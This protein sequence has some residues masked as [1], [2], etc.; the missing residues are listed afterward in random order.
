MA[1]TVKEAR[2]PCLA[3]L[4]CLLAAALAIT[5][6]VQP[7]YLTQHGPI[8]GTYRAWYTSVTTVVASAFASFVASQIRLLWVGGSDQLDSYMPL[9]FGPPG[10]DRQQFDRLRVA[11]GVGR[12]QDSFRHWRITLSFLGTNLITAAIA[13]S[14]TPSLAT[15]TVE[16]NIA[17]SSGLPY[18]PC[19]RVIESGSGN[20]YN[21]PLANGSTINVDVFATACPAV[22]ARGLINGISNL[23]A[24]GYAYSDLGVAVYPGALGAPAEIYESALSASAYGSDALS[25]TQCVRTM[26]SNPVSCQKGGKATVAMLAPDRAGPLTVKNDDGTC[27]GT[28]SFNSNCE[29]CDIMK[30]VT[31]ASSGV[32][33]ATIVLGGS[34]A[35]FTSTVSRWLGVDLQLPTFAVVCTVDTTDA[36]H[37]RNVTLS[38]RN[39]AAMA[40]TSLSRQLNA[41][42]SAGNC[43]NFRAQ[44]N[45]GLIGI[46]AA[47]NHFPFT[48][49][50][51]YGF[52]NS[53][54][55]CVGHS[56]PLYAFPNSRNSLEDC[57]GLTMALVTSRL[58]SATVSVPA[59]TV[60][61]ATRVGS[62]KT[63]GFAYIIP[64][65]FAAFVLVALMLRNAR[66]AFR[67]KDSVFLKARFIPPQT[68][69]SRSAS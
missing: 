59:T 28:T 26:V 15:R 32:G 13:T 2:L 67:H 51:Y 52:L 40:G 20:G 44:D 65:L 35:M 6:T 33:K 45:L 12:W 19:A 22:Y 36:F 4:G 58:N 3:L 27:S 50:N 41:S 8:D 55:I 39:A 34:G 17:V 25:T 69:A 11:L 31:C 23:S 60:L 56:K 64:P 48:E 63:L 5:V 54:E 24:T 7:F 42:S 21:W 49:N 9:L 14:I 38:L 47:A 18:Y 46:A 30:A 16:N 57:L 10:G 61:S 53:M 66:G 29:N 1:L 62:G 43:A 37:F 68:T